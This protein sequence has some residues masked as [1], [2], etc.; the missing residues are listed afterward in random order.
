[1]LLVLG[2]LVIILLVLMGLS[3]NVLYIGKSYEV[4]VSL[5]YV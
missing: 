5:I 1:M 4:T 3:E 2:L